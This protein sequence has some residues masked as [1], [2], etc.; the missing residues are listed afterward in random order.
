MYYLFL[1]KSVA[2]GITLYPPVAGGDGSNNNDRVDA[3]EWWQG[4]I[5]SQCI[6]R[7]AYMDRGGGSLQENRCE[8]MWITIK[9]KQH[10][11]TNRLCSHLFHL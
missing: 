3:D 9:S 2:W 6:E 7:D 1:V 5:V 4:S 11:Y 8:G 10:P